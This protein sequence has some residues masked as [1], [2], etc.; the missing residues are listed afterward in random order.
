MRSWESELPATLSADYRKMRDNL[1]KIYKSSVEDNSDNG[2]KKY[3]TD[4]NF[5]LSVYSYL[6]NEIGIT[7]SDASDDDVWRFI[8]MNV[9]PDL[10]FDRWFE[11]NG[12]DRIN[13][14]RFW[15]DSRRMWL[16]TMWWYIH[17]SLQNDSIEDTKQILVGNSSDDISQL[18][19]R[20]GAGYRT[21]LYRA[22]MLRYSRSES[23][24]KLLLRKVLK[25]NVV[26][27]A[28][29]EPLLFVSGIDDYAESLFAYFEA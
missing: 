14:D 23:D 21:D 13:N 26:R 18:V 19:E 12:S 24:D 9:V 29:I 17:L 22:I 4:L 8:Q 20:S 7:A 2:S 1:W 28:T 10:I 11:G 16:K 5:G 3:L 6:K 27:C 15:K 25:L